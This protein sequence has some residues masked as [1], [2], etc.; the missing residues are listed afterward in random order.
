VW[1]CDEESEAVVADQVIA[2]CDLLIIYIIIIIIII[3]NI[4]IIISDNAVYTK[5]ASRA[6]TE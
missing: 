4:I 5:S 3:I 1:S 6:L 2:V